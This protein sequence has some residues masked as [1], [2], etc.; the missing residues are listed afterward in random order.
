MWVCLDC[1]RSYSDHC[2]CEKC[3]VSVVN[4]PLFLCG[5]TQCIATSNKSTKW[6]RPSDIR[7]KKIRREEIPGFD[8][9]GAL[10]KHVRILIYG[11]YGSGKS[12]FVL[13]FINE[14]SK[15]SWRGKAIYVSAEEG[16]E[17]ATLQQKLEQQK[18]D[19]ANLIIVD[20]ID[21]MWEAVRDEDAHNVV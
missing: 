14:V 7:S 4:I 17:S 1:N 18:I 10:P 8:V 21:D 20:N 12:T 13:K 9:F 3:G 16:V 19:S 15:S 2:K 11:K 5:N 6:K